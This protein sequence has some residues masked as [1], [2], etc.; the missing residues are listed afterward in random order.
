M[1]LS[2]EVKN[3]SV[4]V[5]HDGAKKWI[6]EKQAE[7]IMNQDGSRKTIILDG[8]MYNLSSIAKILSY[9]EY[10]EQ[11][12]PEHQE[13][14]RDTFEDIYGAQG[15]QQIR[16]PTEHAKELMKQG[17]I[18][19][20]LE[21]GKTPEQ[22]ELKWEQFVRAGIDYRLAKKVLQHSL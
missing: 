1:N 8:S 19:Y 11:Y 9:S 4:I 16:Q 20:H 5:F 18:Q 15:N 22:A 14:E 21:K 7:F 2:T 12:P 10:Y 17:F 6:S 3:Q 13:Y